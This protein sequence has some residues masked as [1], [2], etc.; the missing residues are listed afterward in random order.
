ML[1]KN[2]RSRGF[3][4]IELL[5]VI[6]IIAILIALL[7]P[8]VQKVRAAAARAQCANNLK[9]IGLAMHSYHDVLK[10]LPP[11]CIKKSIQDPTTGGAGTVTNMQNNPYN[12]AAFHW[13]FLL[14]PYLDQ[15]PL[16][17]TI[18]MGPPPA[19]PSGSGSNPPNLQTSTAWLNAP[20]RTLLQTPLA[21]M[22]CPATS[23][24]LA[25]DDNSR[26]V[27]IPN[28]AAASYAVVISGIITLNNN[29]DDGSAGSGP[30]QPYGFYELLH[31]RFDGPFNQNVAYR[32]SQISDGTSNTVA[33]GERYRYVQDPGT[34]G[35]GGWGIFALASPHAQN[36]HNLFAGSTGLPFNPV[37]PTPTSDT[38]HLMA[39]SSRHPS[40]VNFV[41]LDGT[42]RFLSDNLAAS[43]RTAIGTRA[44]NE[45]FSLD[46]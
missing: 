38:S 41:F 13:S 15:T 33:V 46:N 26:G 34:N 39:F 44:G 2:S 9:Q 37:I 12:P 8:A 20:Y 17:A 16:H 29:N 28:R 30:L 23:D 5:V 10:K 35:H 3:T 36:G 22:R 19:P 43:V 25:Y 6:A 4:L 7:V 45:V 24:A 14:L 40:G 1:S 27:L 31:S 18:P 11:A 32:M 21:V 42:V